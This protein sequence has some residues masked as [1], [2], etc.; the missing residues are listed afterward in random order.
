L[1][2]FDQELSLKVILAVPSGLLGSRIFLALSG[3][4]AEIDVRELTEGRHELLESL[5]LIEHSI[6]KA[7][8]KEL[9]G[10]Q[11]GVDRA[12]IPAEPSRNL[13]AI[14]AA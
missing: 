12:M 1:D 2:I 6:L 13:W 9:R 7:P 8:S 11:G 10:A 5:T 14:G 4:V 3:K